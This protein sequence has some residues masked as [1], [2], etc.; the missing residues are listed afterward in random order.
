M[1]YKIYLI[2][3]VLFAIVD[4]AKIVDK[5]AQECT[6]VKQLVISNILVTLLFGI[7]VP[8]YYAAWR[9]IFG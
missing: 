3:M 7:T 2:V 9:F 4:Y 6:S 8:L 1:I 5:M